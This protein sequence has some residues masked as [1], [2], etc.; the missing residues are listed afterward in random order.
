MTRRMLLDAGALIALSRGDGGARAVLASALARGYQIVVP[1]PVVAQ[2]HCGGRS[3][4]RTDRILNGIDD[5]SPTSL[6]TARHAGELLARAG[7]TD[8]VDAIVAAEA[9]AGAHTVVLTGDMDHLSRLV[10]AGPGPELVEVVG[11]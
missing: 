11:I 4:A 10:E 7:M 8:A 1:T 6:Q 3:H 2:V 5:F 9:L